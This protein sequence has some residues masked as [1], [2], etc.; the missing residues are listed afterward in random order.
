MQKKKSELRKLKPSE[1]DLPNRTKLFVN[2]S[3]CPYYRC[4]WNQ[5]KKLYNKQE[6]FSFSTV[7]GSVRIKIRENGPYNIITHIDDLKGTFLEVSRCHNQSLVLFGSRLQ[8][9]VPVVFLFRNELF[10][11]HFSRRSISL[12]NYQACAL[13]RNNSLTSSPC[14]CFYVFNKLLL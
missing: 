1:L 13:L 12:D 4:L 9:V 2:E 10:Y 11:W 6:I 14:N 7:N 5:C 8:K 3:L